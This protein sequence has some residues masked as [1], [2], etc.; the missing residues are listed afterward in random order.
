LA[1]KLP[2]LEGCSCPLRL[3][4]WLGTP[5]SIQ[6]VVPIKQVFI[7]E[8]IFT[9]EFNSH[10][11]A[12]MHAI[13]RVTGIRYCEIHFHF[14]SFQFHFAIHKHMTCPATFKKMDVFT[15]AIA[16]EFLRN[17]FDPHY[18]LQWWKY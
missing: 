14:L 18:S 15:T 8:L 7:A 17:G 12:T 10:A 3:L 5:L 9:L 1:G 4:E 6:E 16:S 13:C 11:N 2:A